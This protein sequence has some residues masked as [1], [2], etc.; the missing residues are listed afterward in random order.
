[1]LLPGADVVAART[2]AARMS[3]A[4]AD[5][6]FD[7]D[8]ETRVRVSMGGA[9]WVPPSAEGPDEVIF[10]AGEHLRMAQIRGGGV[11]RDGDG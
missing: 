6:P 1:M 8:G 11:V 7:L 5:A 3:K 4:V 9:V 10:R 2:V